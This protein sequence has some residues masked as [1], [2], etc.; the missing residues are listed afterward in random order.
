MVEQ[1]AL[2][3][4]GEVTVEEMKA[5]GPVFTAGSRHDPESVPQAA[6]A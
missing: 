1:Q 2:C 6:G 4:G 5:A 3:G